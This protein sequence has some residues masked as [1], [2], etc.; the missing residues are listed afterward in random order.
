MLCGSDP[1][2]KAR[3]SMD[4][5][6]TVLHPCT[7]PRSEYCRRRSQTAHFIVRCASAAVRS[8][9]QR[10]S[11]YR[12]RLPDAAPVQDDPRAPESPL[13]PACHSLSAH[14][15]PRKLPGPFE[16]LRGRGPGTECL[17]HDGTSVHRSTENAMRWD[18]IWTVSVYRASSPTMEHVGIWPH[19]TLA[20]ALAPCPRAKTLCPPPHRGSVAS[21]GT[22]WVKQLV[23]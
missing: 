5:T 12:P 23:I 14:A 18:F 17:Q 10:P 8:S 13:Q 7:P 20:P 2:Q 16:R 11:S 6:G 9:G 15:S 3:L 4:D 21:H 19:T 1:G 22:T